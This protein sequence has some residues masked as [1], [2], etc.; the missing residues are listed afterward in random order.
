[1]DLEQIYYY[2]NPYHF[3]D[4]V[5]KKYKGIVNIDFNIILDTITINVESEHA[6][7]KFPKKIKLKDHKKGTIFK[8]EINLLFD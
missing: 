8:I 3:L 7:Q 4:V 1:M 5:S 2:D 6:H